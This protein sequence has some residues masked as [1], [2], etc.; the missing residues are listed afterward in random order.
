MLELF[1]TAE[2]G[3][4]DDGFRIAS[5]VPDD[6]CA[7]G[8]ATIRGSSDLRSRAFGGDKRLVITSVVCGR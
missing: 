3:V 7:F 6:H 4:G 8:L 1:H 5:I 2:N